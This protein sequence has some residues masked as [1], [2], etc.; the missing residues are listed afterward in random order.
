MRVMLLPTIPKG[1]V[2]ATDCDAMFKHFKKQWVDKDSRSKCEWWLGYTIA[3][4]DP[5]N[6]GTSFTDPAMLIRYFTLFE[7]LPFPAERWHLNMNLRDHIDAGP[8]LVCLPKGVT[9][10]DPRS[11]AKRRPKFRNAEMMSKGNVRLHLN[12]LVEKG[13]TAN[14]Q[15]TKNT[16]STVR[17]VAHILAI[18]TGVVLIE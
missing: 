1:S 10:T 18:M 9:H 6:S 8:W 11:K 5:A 12:Q 7:S 14:L 2:H 13:S 3:K 4:A 16:A 15:F 17:F